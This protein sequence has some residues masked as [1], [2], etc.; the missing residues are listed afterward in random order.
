MKVAYRRPAIP[1]AARTSKVK[2]K[3]KLH[4]KQGAWLLLFTIVHRARPTATTRPAPPRSVGLCLVGWATIA[5]R[6]ASYPR[7]VATIHA[8][9]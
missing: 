1:H 7:G 3:F 5:S 4:S 2:A 8:S 6:I 9:N